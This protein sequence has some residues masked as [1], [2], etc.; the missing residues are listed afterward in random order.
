MTAKI[1]TIRDFLHSDDLNA[2][3]FGLPGVSIRDNCPKCNIVVIDDLG[4]RGL[5]MPKF[6]QSL[7]RI[8][9]CPECDEIWTV[10]LVLRISL[11]LDQ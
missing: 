7:K 10:H 3:Y 4:S 6:N 1:E 11:E 8:I 5:F 2:K 9:C